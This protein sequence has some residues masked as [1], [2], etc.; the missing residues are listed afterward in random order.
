[1]RAEF[2]KSP[3]LTTLLDEWSR[4]HELSD[5]R[6]FLSPPWIGTWVGETPATIDVGCVRVFDD[7]RGVYGLALVGLSPRRSILR[8]STAK[9]HESGLPKLDSIYLEYNDILLARD[10][11]DGAREAAIEAIIDALPGIDEFVFRN[12]RPA[13]VRAIEN[14]AADRAMKARTALSQPTFEIALG[15]APVID[16]LSPSLKAKIR[17][18]MRRYEE[19]GPLVFERAENA[20]DRSVFWT[21]LMRLHA[22]TWARR[23]K[24]G[25]FREPAFTGFHTRLIEKFPASIDLVRLTAGRETVG[26]L[27]NFVGDDRV[28]N[29][30]S[31][32]LYEADNQFAPGFVSHV[33]AAERYRDEGHSVYDLMGGGGDY[34]IRL[35]REGETLQSIVIT[36][37]GVRPRMRSFGQRL[38]RARFEGMRQT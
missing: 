29:Y 30:Q 9:I 26:V 37:S 4:L 35:G 1:M 16:G 6:F 18:S 31:G 15:D 22:Q 36:R 34:K 38:M 10:A 11:P 17:R 23:G 24:K 19:R 2:V 28:Y 25:V 27:Y 14:V 32:F 8:T 13:F 5:A 3:D 12:A 20:E 21:G 33:L 7:L